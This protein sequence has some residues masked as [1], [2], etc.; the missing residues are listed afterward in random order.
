MIVS[1]GLSRYRPWKTGRMPVVSNHVD[2][3]PT[4]L[5]LCGV[6]YPDW[7]ESTDLSDS[8]N[9]PYR[10]VVTKYGCKYV[11]F[12]GRSW[13]MF[14]L[15]EDPFEEANVAQN[16]CYHAERRKLIAR[17]KQWAS[18]THDTFLSRRMNPPQMINADR[19]NALSAFGQKEALPAI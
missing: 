17:V 18:D 5:G 15:N 12:E 14:K 13:L 1:G 4:T 8:I 9:I 11:C 7:I 2:I 10:D 3:T 16:N 6:S 19:N